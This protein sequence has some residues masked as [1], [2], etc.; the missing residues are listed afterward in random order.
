MPAIWRPLSPA[1]QAG[2]LS[3]SPAI[4]RW[5]RTRPRAR[6]VTSTDEY[7]AAVAPELLDRVKELLFLEVTATLSVEMRTS[8][9]TGI[10]STVTELLDLDL[11]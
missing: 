1:R 11:A 6:I 10:P 2:R 9:A 8:L 3:T 4:S 7:L 5:D